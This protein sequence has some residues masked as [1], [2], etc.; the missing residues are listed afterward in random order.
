MINGIFPRSKIQ[1]FIS[2]KIKTNLD[3]EQVLE[4]VTANK[5]PENLLV[6]FLVAAQ[7]LAWIKCFPFFNFQFSPD[8][9]DLEM[10]MNWYGNILTD[11]LNHYGV[12][13]CWFK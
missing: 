10:E 13:I 7:V 11:I 9:S 3:Q 8:I 4:L 1:R 2:K 12:E 5:V 6:E